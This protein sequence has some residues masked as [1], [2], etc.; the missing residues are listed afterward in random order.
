MQLQAE[1]NCYNNVLNCNVMQNFVT[2]FIVNSLSVNVNC[3]ADMGSICLVYNLNFVQYH[4]GDLAIIIYILLKHS[5]LCF[6]FSLTLKG[7]GFIQKMCLPT[8]RRIESN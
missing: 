7:I 2:F 6:V 8:K 4:F 5:F 1:N 3:W